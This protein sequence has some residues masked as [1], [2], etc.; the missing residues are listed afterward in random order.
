MWRLSVYK[1]KN[2]VFICIKITI[3]LMQIHI[4]EKSL[5]K[6]I[7]FSCIEEPLVYEMTHNN[8]IPNYSD[9]IIS[10][11]EIIFPY[12]HFLAI[13]VANLCVIIGALIYLIDDREYHGKQMI[14][15]S[16][17]ALIILTI[18]FSG[19]N[20]ALVMNSEDLRMFESFYHFTLNYLLFILAA[21]SI[22]LFFAS[23]GL[24]LIDSKSKYS[25]Y[26][27]KSIICLI[28]VLVPMGM[29]FPSIPN[30]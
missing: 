7:V 15:R 16:L 26:M 11:F 24:F 27:R 25:K 17:L 9:N 29:K 19:N 21:L 22:I 14:L 12:I 23:C 5:L 20:T 18:V 30:I 3:F 8:A 4:S 28:A 6:E 2:W 1:R 10:F 13:M